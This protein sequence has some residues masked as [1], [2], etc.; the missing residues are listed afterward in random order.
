MYRNRVGQDTVE[1]AA[2]GKFYG[3]PVLVEDRLYCIDTSGQVV[4]LRA[5]ASYERL[6]INDLGEASHATPA[7]ANGRMILRTNSRLSCIAASNGQ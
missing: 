5:A 1:R 4:V 2:R 3:S 6:A 7:V